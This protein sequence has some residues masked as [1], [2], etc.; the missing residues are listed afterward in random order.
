M[1]GKG[2]QEKCTCDEAKLIHAL[3]MKHTIIIIITP[4]SFYCIKQYQTQC[5]NAY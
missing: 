3:L 2:L 1:V 5:K 4:M